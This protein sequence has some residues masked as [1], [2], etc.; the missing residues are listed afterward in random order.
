MLFVAILTCAAVT[1]GLRYLP[2][3][4]AHRL[5]DREDLRE[6][7]ALLPAGLMLILVAYTFLQADSGIQVTRLASA[8]VASLAVHW[9]SR[10]FLVSFIAGFAVYSLTALVF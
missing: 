5:R 3:R 1:F 8:A 4:V 2:M 10:N 9:V 7:S 6:I